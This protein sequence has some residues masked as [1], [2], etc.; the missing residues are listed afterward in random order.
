MIRVPGRPV[1]LTR[2]TIPIG[3]VSA[4][5][6]VAMLAFLGPAAAAGPVA[7]HFGPNG[8]IGGPP[9]Y[10]ASFFGPSPSIAAGTNGV[11]Y[12]AFAGWSGATTGDDID[13]TMSSDGGRSWSTPIRVNDDAGAA[14]QAEPS[15]ALDPSN[16]IYIVWTDMRSG[17]NDVYFAKSVNGGLTFGANLRVNDITTNSQSEP[18]LAVD[19]V[20]PHLVHVVWTDTRSPILGPDIFYANST[21]GGLS[22]NPSVP[23]NDDVTSTEQSQPAIAVAPNP[24]VDGVWRGPRSAAQGPGMYFSKV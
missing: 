8:Q 20:N 15:L 17:N 22:F 5:L 19:P 2:R 12:L 18:D 4:L 7:P 10:R 24:D 21:N 3:V 11:V 13:F 9:V 16:N 23:V 6:A 1:S 14:A